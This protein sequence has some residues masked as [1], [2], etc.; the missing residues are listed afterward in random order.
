MTIILFRIIKIIPSIITNCILIGCICLHQLTQ[1]QASMWNPIA[2]NYSIQSLSFN[3]DLFK[4]VPYGTGLVL[5]RR[6][7]STGTTFNV[8]ST[9]T[10][11]DKLVN[12]YWWPPCAVNNL[13][14]IEILRYASFTSCWLTI[15]SSSPR[16]W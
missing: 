5:W 4:Y 16:T 1:K 15:P 9:H 11:D 7:F 2:P 14:F 10:G 13:M 6:Y 8:Q 3:I 12:G